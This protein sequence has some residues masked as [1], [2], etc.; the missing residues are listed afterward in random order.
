MLSDKAYF[1]N[2]RSTCVFKQV[3]PTEL[4]DVIDEIS[5]VISSCLVGIYD[6]STGFD[7]LFGFVVK[8][9]TNVQLTEDFI[10]DYVN[11]RV[12]DAKR[13]RGGVHFLDAL[14]ITVNGKVDKSAV[15][16]VA[17]RLRDKL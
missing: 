9:P 8:D 3:Y 11:S 7:Q 17:L 10:L 5:G 6:E 14:P 1:G 16:K 12:I 13:L 2:K 4:E 15:R